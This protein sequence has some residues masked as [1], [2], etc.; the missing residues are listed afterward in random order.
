[1]DDSF[2]ENYNRIFSLL[3]KKIVKFILKFYVAAYNIY[4]WYW[5]YKIIVD[6]K[7]QWDWENYAIWFFAM[8]GQMFFILDNRVKIGIPKYMKDID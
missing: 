1:M 2:K 3:M 6:P 4:G 7:L 5:L 8:A